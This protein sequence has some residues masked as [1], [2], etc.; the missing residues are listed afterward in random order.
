NID[1]AAKRVEDAFASILTLAINILATFVAGNIT[2]KVRG[3]IFKLRAWVDKG[4]DKV[5]DWVLSLGK[6]LLAGAKAGVKALIGWWKAKTSFT[7]DGE[8]HSL[9]FQGEGAAAT[10]I[11]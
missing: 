5:V 4:L 8:D 3:A 1:A 10:L 6:K 7:A 9:Y 11:V 2:D